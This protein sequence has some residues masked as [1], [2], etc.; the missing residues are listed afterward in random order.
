[1]SLRR[2]AIA[3]LALLTLVLGAG[4]C[5]SSKKTGDATTSVPATTSAAPP[6]IKAKLGPCPLVYPRIQLAVL[7]AG[8]KGL[9]TKLVP[10]E[11]ESVRV[12]TYSVTKLT[13]SG[14]VESDAASK[15]EADTNALP[16]ATNR[17]DCPGEKITRL[18]F[19]TF[20][21]ASH[22]VQVG[23]SDACGGNAGNGAFVAEAKQAWADEVIRI[24]TKKAPVAP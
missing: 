2:P 14:T 8:V 17:L 5:S 24:A 6:K 13:A 3:A 21:D 10:L 4:A 11:A 20:Q 9:D 22:R 19:V 1:M 12:C 16:K 18:F 23:A 7:N 15:F